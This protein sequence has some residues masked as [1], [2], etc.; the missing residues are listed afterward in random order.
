MK[1]KEL[2]LGNTYHLT[3]INQLGDREHF[4]IHQYGERFVVGEMAIHVRD[5]KKG[6]DYWFIFS[7]YRLHTGAYYK[8][9]FIL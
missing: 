7:D 2:K 8:L 5:T 4:E 1:R 3:N 9:V 6:H